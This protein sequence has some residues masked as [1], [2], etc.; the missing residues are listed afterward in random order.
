MRG[1]RLL[2]YRQPLVVNEM[3]VEA[4]ITRSELNVNEYLEKLSRASSRDGCGAL[5]M[6]M[7]FVKGLVGEGSVNELIYEAYENYALSKMREIGEEAVKKFG[8]RDVV[9]VHRVGNLRPGDPTIYIFVTAKS[10][11]EA[12]K[13]A[14]YVLE[15]VKHEVPISK[16]EVRSD[17]EFWVLG[18][19]RRIRRPRT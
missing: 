10:R 16:L 14:E 4:L 2:Y 15:R 5:V 12:F 17:G 19:G 3:V 7:G 8:V 6:F 9:V 13:A 1:M 11:G 18:D